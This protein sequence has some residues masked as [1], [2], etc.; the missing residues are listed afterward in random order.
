MVTQKKDAFEA[1]EALPASYHRDPRWLEVQRLRAE[2]KSLEAN[3]LVLAIRESYGFE[4]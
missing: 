4:G 3:E 1:Y 2:N